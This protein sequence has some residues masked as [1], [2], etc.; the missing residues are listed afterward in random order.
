MA[1]DPLPPCPTTPQYFVVNDTQ[2]ATTLANMASCSGGGEFNVRWQGSVD[3][4]ETITVTNGSILTIAGF[5]ADEAIADGSGATRL[6]AVSGAFLNITD[7]QLKNGNSDDGG[8]S[9]SY[10]SAASSSWLHKGGGAIS[11]TEYSTVTLRRTSFKYNNGNP[12]GA[13]YAVDS[14]VTLSEESSFVE[15]TSGGYGGAVH[16]IGGSSSLL[17][18]NGRTSFISNVAEGQGGAVYILSAAVVS[19]SG[20]V[21][22]TD[23]RAVRGGAIGAQFGA[24]VSWSGTANFSGNYAETEGGAVWGIEAKYT[25]L[26]SAIFDNNFA[27]FA[28]GAVFGVTG[29]ELVWRGESRFSDNNSTEG[30][31]LAVDLSSNAFLAGDTVFTG[32]WASG[33]S[34][35]A[36]WVGPGSLVSCAGTTL[37]ADNVA[38]GFG[39]AIADDALSSESFGV[40]ATLLFETGSSTT[41]EENVSGTNG[42]ALAWAEGISVASSTAIVFTRNSAGVSGGAVYLS[43]VADGLT[44]PSGVSFIANSAQIGGAVYSLASGTTVATSEEF[45]VVYNGTLF[46][47]NTASTSGGAV[48][49]AAGKDVF[50]Y[51]Q[52]VNNTAGIGGALRLAGTSDLIA[53]DFV[54][55]G[56]SIAG[57]AVSNVGAMRQVSNVSF[58]DNVLLCSEGTFLDYEVRV[59]T[60]SVGTRNDIGTGRYAR[61]RRS[62]PKP[63]GRSGF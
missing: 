9:S 7:L 28:G 63:A 13:L 8:S 6:F 58:V 60:T 12:G 42:G 29:A 52:F 30:G 10:F 56:A 48:E 27:G 55:N 2:G 53:C 49:S 1:G 3:V 62:G 39:G 36:V 21:S 17:S 54:A 47:G 19:W 5:G 22:Y 61:G 11:A 46:Q 26:G 51:T 57:P 50:L 25:W 44:W 34:G 24:D 18:C 23:N 35:G 20:E 32:N 40:L 16:F 4:E 38:T 37:F 31:A 14:N 45:P 59:S 15:N 43:A 41:F 33:A